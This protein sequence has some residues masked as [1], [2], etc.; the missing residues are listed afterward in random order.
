MKNNKTVKILI[1]VLVIVISLGLG[2]MFAIGNKEEAIADYETKDLYTIENGEYKGSP[3]NFRFNVEKSGTYDFTIEVNCDEC[4]GFVTA[5][6]LKDTSGEVLCWDTGA[7]FT[8]SG[9]QVE[10]KE[11]LYTV[12]YVILPTEEELNDFIQTLDSSKDFVSF[13]DGKDGEWNIQR[14]YRVERANTDT[15]LYIGLG[16]LGGLAI[17]GLLVSLMTKGNK[18][19]YDERQKIHQGKAY[20]YAFITLLAFEVAVF[21]LQVSEINLPVS[22]ANITITGIDL[23]LAVFAVYSVMTDCY[24]ALNSKKNVVLSVLT[25]GDVLSLLAS[26]MIVIGHSDIAYLCICTTLVMT[27]VLI[28]VIIKLLVDKKNDALEDGEED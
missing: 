5:V 24:F 23:S 8:V 28:S 11:G 1:F 7:F 20:K 17:G 25:T 6:V 9:R 13:P 27:V 19:I 4:P 10:L 12:E 15:K 18:Q 16:C 3:S 2:F 14:I 22:N 26:I 21:T